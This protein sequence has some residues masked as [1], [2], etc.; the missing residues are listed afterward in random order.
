MAGNSN[1]SNERN[2]HAAALSASTQSGRFLTLYALASAGGSASYAPFLT[3]LLPARAAEM[4]GAGAVQMLSYAAF[5]GA[6]AASLS[7]IAFGWASD[8]TRNRRGWIVAGLAL[9]CALLVSM[10][11]IDTLPRL[12]AAICVWQV[13]L[14]MMLAPLAAWAGDTVPDNQKGFLGGLMSLAPGTGAMV[15]AIVTLP[16]LATADQRLVLVAVIVSAMVLPAVFWGNPKPMP[17]LTG[18]PVRPATARS[19]PVPPPRPANRPAATVRRMWLARL[20]MQISEAALFAFLFLWLRDL[21]PRISDHHTATIFTLVTLGAA[22]LALTAGRW[23]DRQ[24][25]PMTPL[26]VA[27]LCGAAGLAVM[28]MSVTA[29][30]AIAGYMV[31]GVSAGVFLA[32]HTSQTLRVL[33]RPEHRGRDLGFFNLTNTFPSLIMPAFS[34]TLVPAFGFRGLF[35][36]LAILACLSGLLLP[37]REERR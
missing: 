30:A 34:L 16:G 14:N 24:E 20:L 5:L 28:A 35:V 27:T 25:R 31:F 26:L 11:F 15:G 21:N 3:L 36:L 19:Q 4:A 2:Q 17:Q 18:D 32:L 6:V 7:N 33:P 23:S 9:S 37:R 8:R 1:S 12:L 22:P 13:A 29:T 10:Q